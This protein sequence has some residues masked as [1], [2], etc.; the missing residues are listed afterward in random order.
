MAKSTPKPDLNLLKCLIEQN[1]LFRGME[2]SWLG[3]YLSPSLIKEEKLFSN[4]PIY[5]AF[6]PNQYIDGLYVILGEG[7]VIARSAPLDRI[8]SITYPGSCFGIRSLP[9]SFGLAAQGFPS[10]VEAYKTTHI[11]KIPL[12][13]LQ[14]LYQES[15]EFRQRYHLLFELRQKFQYHLLNCSTYPPQAVASL[16][17]ALIY[18][19]R[20]LGN[21]PNGKGIYQFDLPIDIIARACQL[22]QRTVEQVLKGMQKAGLLAPAK[23][24]EISADFVWVIDPEGLKEVYSATRD[25]VPWWPLR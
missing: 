22:N 21:Q 3:Q 12:E 8:I 1:F 11:V 23:N 24:T 9:F 13:T 2:E 18:Q 19:E 20:E 25:K 7:L 17:R 5:T 15:E 4:R 10:L 6:R 14:T 16:L